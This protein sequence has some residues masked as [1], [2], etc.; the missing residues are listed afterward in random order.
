[1]VERCAETLALTGPNTCRKN[2][3]QASIIGRRWSNFC[4]PVDPKKT[5]GRGAHWG[6]APS[7]AKLKEPHRSLGVGRRSCRYTEV[8]GRQTSAL[9]LPL[10]C[11]RSTRG[12][13]SFKLGL[14]WLRK[15]TTWRITHRKPREADVRQA[16]VALFLRPC[17]NLKKGSII[18]KIS[19]LTNVLQYCQSFSVLATQE[20]RNIHILFS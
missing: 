6:S 4:D 18:N 11:V 2:P 16:E 13:A 5:N 20:V 3:P 10:R 17:Y 9:P 14:A 7:A 19:Y 15:T 8:K 1:M 12:A